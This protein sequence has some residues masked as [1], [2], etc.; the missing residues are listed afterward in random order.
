MKKLILLILGFILGALAMYFY[1]HKQEPIEMLPSQPNGLIKPDEIKTLT[2]AY[3]PRYEAINDSLFNGVDGGDNRSS[4]YALEDVKNYLVLAKNQA[5]SLGYTMDGIR[6]YPGAHPGDGKNPGYSTY[7]FVPTG[8]L[9]TSQG[10][11][12]MM[13]KGGGDDIDGGDGLNHGDEGRPPSANYP[14]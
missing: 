4:W 12:F 1:C 10:N 2:Q 13:Q 9:K 8:Y 11:M 6:I 7:I 5:D 3:N 14:Q